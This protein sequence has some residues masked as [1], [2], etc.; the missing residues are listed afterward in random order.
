MEIKYSVIFLSIDCYLLAI[1]YLFTWQCFLPMFLHTVI[2]FFRKTKYFGVI[3][4]TTINSACYIYFQV[5]NNFDIPDP[6]SFVELNIESFLWGVFESIGKCIHPT[7][8]PVVSLY[9]LH[10]VAH[11]IHLSSPNCY[12]ISF[13]E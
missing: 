13:L 3:Y 4:N 11:F 2:L 10:V 8:F 1:M 5:L 7:L 9:F 6:C 12:P